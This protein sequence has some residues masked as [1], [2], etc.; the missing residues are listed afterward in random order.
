MRSVAVSA[1]RQRAERLRGQPSTS[2]AGAASASLRRPAHLPDHRAKLR[3]EETR[4][5]HPSTCS[6]RFGS[7]GSWSASTEPTN[8]R[9]CPWLPA[10][11][12]A[13]RWVGAATAR[14][15]PRPDPGAA[16]R[17]RPAARNAFFVR[18]LPDDA[19][20]T[21]ASRHASTR[22][23][24]PPTTGSN[25]RT[26]FRDGAAA[27]PLLLADDGAG[28]RH[29]RAERRQHAQRP[30]DAG[31]LRPAQ[32]PRRPQRPAGAGVHLLLHGSPTTSTS[33]G[34]RADG[35]GPGAPAAA[36]PRQ[37]GPGPRARPRDLAGRDGLDLGALAQRHAR[38]RWRGRRR[39]SSTTRVSRPRST[40]TAPR[41]A[42][43]RRGATRSWRSVPSST[44]RRLVH[45]RLAR[46]GPRGSAAQR[47]T[48]HAT[49]GAACTARRWSKRA[50][51]NKVIG[52]ASRQPKDKNEAKRL[53]A[54]GRGPARAADR[55]AT[56]RTIQSDFYS[57]RYFASEGFLPGYSF[58]R[59]PLSAYIPGRRRRGRPRRVPVAPRFLAITEFGPR[60][61]IYHEGVALHRSTRSSCRPS[62][63]TSN[64]LADRRGQAVRGLRLPAPARQRRRRARPV[65]ALRGAARLQLGRSCSGC[66]TSS[67]QAAGPDQLA[68]RR[69]GCARATR[70]APAPVRRARRAAR[71]PARPTVEPGRRDDSR[72][73]TYGHGATIWRINLGWRR[74]TN[75][76]QLGFVLDTE[77]GYWATNDQDPDDADD[78]MSRAASASIPYVEDRRNGLL[79]EPDEPAS[80]RGDG[81]A[82]GGAQDTRSRPRS[83]SRTTSWRPSRSRSDDDGGCSCST[84][85]PRAA[86]ACCGGWSTTRRRSRA[87]A[88][89]GARDLPLRPGHRRDL[90]TPGRTRGLRGGLLRLPDELH[91]PARPRCST[92]SRSRDLLLSL[93]DGRR[94][95]VA[96][97]GQPRDEHLATL[98]ALREL[99]A[100][101]RVARLPSTAA[102]SRCRPTARSCIEAC[103]RPAGLPLRRA[104]RRDLHRRPVH[105]Y[106]DVAE[107]DD[108]DAQRRLEDARLRRD[109]LRRRRQRAGSRSSTQYPNVFGKARR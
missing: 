77:R 73:S 18:L 21:R 52:D 14:A 54:R 33:S 48:T 84:R 59:L 16:R 64:K 89:D 43:P 106:P 85:R 15:V 19:A 87:V 34:G 6:R 51:Q 80:T 75:Q 31:Q 23:R 63:P 30:A 108:R 67:T 22:P 81:L 72:R 61:I 4:A 58:P 107:R 100:R 79:F 17:R 8:G 39:S 76:D 65:R 7:R 102:A 101:A 20:E 88:R 24:C 25:A 57:Y 47:S 98:R 3:V 97:G 103:R 55:E 91:Q 104:Q 1:A 71:R 2:R 28:R 53:R 90:R 46:R 70:S 27:D 105:D 10:P 82:A 69:S 99:R 9:R 32:R 60:S 68:T 94:R 29:R 44:E 109:P 78:P 74:R 86:P 92:A 49:A 36:R 66:R 83:S 35:R 13:M 95:V 11:A 42:R 45:R 26:A 12:A 40:A 38:R 56:S 96:R 62:G 5:G 41:R 37:R 50:A 93:A